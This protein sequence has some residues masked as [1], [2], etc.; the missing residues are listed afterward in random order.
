MA[1]AGVFLQAAIAIAMASSERRS[2]PLV[3][4]GSFCLDGMQ[5]ARTASL[6]NGFDG[7]QAFYL[8]FIYLFAKN[9]HN[10]VCL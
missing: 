2:L 1:T 7:R 8:S 6:L 4:I 3:L 9:L 10:A 5:H